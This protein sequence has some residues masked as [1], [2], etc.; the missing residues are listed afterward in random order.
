[1]TTP[2]PDWNANGVLPPVAVGVSGNSRNRSPYIVYLTEF[3]EHFAYSVERI[4]ILEGF[5]RF[6]EELH[7]KGLDSGFQWLDGSFLENIEVLENRPPEDLDVVTFFA[8][9]TTEK[10]LLLINNFDA[11][12]WGKER[13]I[14]SY[15][16]QTDHADYVKNAH[17]I[18]Y[19]YSMWSHRRDGLWKG[20]V[21][22]D[23]DSTYDTEAKSILNNKKENYNELN[24]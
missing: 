24:K 8:E 15:F 5:L 7:K 23:L 1:M 22:V 13:G 20:F 2:I 10:Q 6:R 17:I 3:V 16:A 14:D 4:A 21:Q 11:D 18:S 19:W 12:Y 9:L